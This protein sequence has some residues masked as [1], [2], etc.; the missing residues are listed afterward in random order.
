MNTGGGSKG[1]NDMAK[2]D[3]RGNAIRA[4]KEL[5]YDQAVI[6]RIRLAKN[7]A[8]IERIMRTARERIPD[9][10]IRRQTIRLHLDMNT[11]QWV[12]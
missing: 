3:Y 2:I 5:K 8:E 10:A 1:G 12:C 9:K 7:D 6:N 4:A 11:F